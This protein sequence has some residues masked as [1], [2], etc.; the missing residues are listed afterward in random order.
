MSDL[1]TFTLWARGLLTQEAGDL[2]QQVYRLDVQTGAR[3]PI[4]HGHLLENS[5]E[6]RTI[7]E[8]IE[9]L[10]T[11]EV[12]A[13]LKREEAVAK[14]IKE[15]AFT[16][17]NR[18]V[19]F[20]LMEGAGLI[21]SP[22]A[23]RHEANGF[24][25]WLGASPEEEALY[26]QGDS[27]NDRD[28][29][30][31]AP[32]DRAYRHF[33]LWQCGE[34]AREIKVLFDPD[35]IPSLLFPRPGVLK[36]LVDTLN[37]DE[38]KVD[39]AAGNEETVGWVYQYF[40]AEEKAAAFDKVFKKKK[41]FE[42]DDLPAATQIFTPRWVVR[43]LVENSLGRLWLFMHQDSDLAERCAYLTPLPAGPPASAMKPAREIRVLDPAT[44]TMHFGLVAFDLLAEMYRE[45][46]THAGRP[47]WP[48]QPSVAT[49]S[50]IPAAIL[51]NNLF[52]IDID[53]R[54][55]Q[56]AALA[57]YLKAKG[58]N[59]QATLTQSNLAC[60]DVTIF[61]GQH[62]TK[63]SGEMAL[64][65]GI[66]GELFVKFRDSLEEASMM[67]SLVRLD[68]HFQN[69]ESDPL[70]QSID[71]YVE[72]K[73]A[74]GIDESYFANE[75]GK[76]IRLL[77]VLERRYDVVCTNPPYMS[78]RNMNSAMSD[79]MKRNYRKSKGDLYSAFIERCAELLG[80]E[81]RQ[82]MITQQSFMFIS[83][84]ANLRDVLLGA[85]AIETM[86]HVGPR[87]FA[88]VTGEKVNTTAFV[89]RREQ[90]DMERRDARG[91]YFRL[92]K[93]PDAE[94][95]RTAFEQA[96]AR[97]R[98]GQPE[99][100]VYEYRQ[101]DF[102]AIPGSPWVYWITPGLLALFSKLKK[103]EDVAQPR[104]G[105][106]TGFNERYLRYW[107]E[108][109]LPRVERTATNGIS[110]DKSGKRWFPYMKGG[111]F[112]RWFGNQDFIV[113]WLR[114]GQ[115][116]KAC[117]P[118]S[119]IRNPECYF[120]RGV[121]WTDLTARKFSAR[122][123]PGGFV[124]DVSG[125]SVFPEDLELVLAVMN[126]TWAQYALKLINPTV[127]V[128]VGDL[129]RLPLPKHSS[130]QLRDSA[131]RAIAFARADSE[132]DETAYDFIAPPAWPDG[133]QL[134]TARHRDLAGL[135]KEIDEEIYR[136]YEISPED[137][138]AIEEELAAA[139][140]SG[141]DAEED[142]AKGD[143]EAADA[144]E[145]ASLTQE[146]LAHRWVSFAVGVALGRFSRPGLESLVD[147]DGLMV[148]QRD[149]PD[150]LAARAIAILATIHGDAESGRI[151]G[152]VI[153]DNGDLRDALAS[154][155][156]GP[157]FKAHVKRYRKRPVY[158]LVQ[159]PKQKYSLYLF[160]ERATDQ[161]L[162]ILQGA[163]YLGGRIFQ[164]KQHLE[165]ANRQEADAEGREKAKWRKQ[166]QDLAEELAD[167]EAIDQA[168]TATNNEPL[169]DAEGKTTT[170]RWTPESDDGVL[171]NAAPLYR[172]TPAWKKADAKLDLGKAWKSLKDG[173]YPWAKTAMRYWP[174]ETLKACKDNKS[175]RI[176]HGLE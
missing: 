154:Y 32:R 126:S 66:T 124:F 146:E 57:L 85:T 55:A 20:K 176:A 131:N 161:T 4:P 13:G 80:P 84:F 175:Y 9:K 8:R 140:E 49:E 162:A 61:R 144:E 169:V 31:E 115:E 91:I 76:G 127:H 118:N 156:L 5:A 15:T 86:A 18:L 105:L 102:A 136:L 94:S 121:T 7:R 116:I 97:R 117:T 159:S 112:Q 29:F 143:E 104:V 142:E 123:S 54:A 51:S 40:N 141:D 50:E 1:R 106:Q 78:N 122:L 60:A 164:L 99:S 157:F 38:R 58:A 17:L 160:H 22:L 138:R 72:K 23:R 71:A 43:F 83:S 128:Q 77:N 152:T 166:A 65:R 82:A 73:R 129:A 135:E 37:A 98:A 108:V 92:V 48:A 45:E 30:G 14:L 46:L 90:L 119:V 42:K 28:G 19:A 26:S 12:D 100:R 87:A 27:P 11:D 171:L 67:G 96:L 155:L 149:H 168:I 173:E 125:S 74:E 153:G 36:E 101:G 151:I 70:R 110:A 111:S 95:K 69:F 24:K 34:L 41:K 6:A 44:G 89:L 75:T 56:L 2:F 137:R 33:L 63:I 134:V 59:K 163:R 114:D 139:P 79:F 39:W 103:L 53:L 167:L 172:L 47:G 150:D 170:S 64:P 93:E 174:R 35:N 133:A 10:L 145:A 68:K 3:L 52:G 21:R 113:N 109:G 25:M 130:D 81:G 107:W 132:E 120:R 62:L 147:E 16:H 148:V 165:E 88:E 158:W